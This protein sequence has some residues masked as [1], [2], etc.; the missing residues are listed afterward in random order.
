MG[1]Q[2][3]QFANSNPMTLFQ[4]YELRLGGIILEDIFNSD[5][6]AN[7]LNIYESTDKRL[8]IANFGFRNC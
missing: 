3:L 1:A 7:L 5:R 4:R 8:A 2:P 6:L